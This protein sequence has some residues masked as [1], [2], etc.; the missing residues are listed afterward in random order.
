MHRRLFLFA[1]Q[2]SLNF[3][4]LLNAITILSIIHT[5]SIINYHRL[6]MTRNSEL[7]LTL[8]SIWSKY[9]SL[10]FDINIFYSTMFWYN[11]AMKE[12]I[13]QMFTNFRVVDTV[14]VRKRISAPNECFVWNECCHLHRKLIKFIVFNFI[15]FLYLVSVSI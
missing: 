6:E 12:V 11:M 5:G 1:S 14:I 9:E 4:M 13:R 8:S 15:R 7:T 2:K 3:I 10:A